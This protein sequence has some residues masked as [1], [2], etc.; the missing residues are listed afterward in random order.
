MIALRKLIAIFALHALAASGIVMTGPVS[1]AQ[2]TVIAHRGASGYL[3]EH[4]LAAKALAHGMGA[5]FIEQDLVLTSDGVPVVLHD[6][7]L[8]TVTDVAARFPPR[9]RDDGRYYAIDFTLAE[10]KS[11]GV[12]ERFDRN[13]GEAVYKGRFPRDGARFAV[14]TFEEEIA[15]IKGLN[16]STGRTVGIYPEIKSPAFHRAE[17]QD[18]SRIVLAILAKHGYA[19][20]ADAVIVQCFDWNETQRLRNELGYAGRLVQLIGENKWNEAPGV[21]F[22]ALRTPQGLAAI[23]T[24]A[25]GIGP[26]IPHVV[27]GAGGDAVTKLVADAHAAGLVVHPYTARADALPDWAG[28]MDELLKA[29]LVTA[30][31]DGVFTDFP[32]QAVRY[33]SSI[34]AP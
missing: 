11:L 10:I 4:T 9:K 16:A 31:A 7:H 20:K 13:T 29:I 3:P 2:K 21:D 30:A 34:G 23:A 22:D 25:D 6:I 1:A 15:L 33:V 5:D 14:A 27:S 26:W 28:S 12:S 17:G 24:M 8:D 18:I 19:S 32:D